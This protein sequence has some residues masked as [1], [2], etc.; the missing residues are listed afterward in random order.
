M[1][2]RTFIQAAGAAAIL[3]VKAIA[4]DKYPSKLITWICPYAA[5]GNA[6]LRSRQLSSA[7]A[8]LMSD[9]TAYAI[10]KAVFD[11]FD[12]FK[13][14][15]PALATLTKADALKGETVPFH[16]GAIKYFKEAGLM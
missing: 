4:Q 7:M 2:R 5:G 13:K 12:D 11:N 15:H 9:A 6:D 16:P 10:T 8:K 14:L 1:K 3:P